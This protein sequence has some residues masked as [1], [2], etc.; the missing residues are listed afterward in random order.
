MILE[1]QPWKARLATDA[2]II[3]RWSSKPSISVR[4][5]TILEQKVFLAAYTIRRL[6]EANKLS[7]ALRDRAISCLQFP[8]I[9]HAKLDLNNNHKLDELYNFAAPSSIVVE[10]N[11]LVNVIIHSLAFAEVIN[12]DKTT[13]G[14]LVA[15]DRSR[16]FLWQVSV[17]EFTALMR[18]VSTDWPSKMIR[19]YDP[20]SDEWLYWLGN[21]EPPTEF[22]EQAERA[23]AATL[24][25]R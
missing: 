23:R 2:D 6:L 8:S 14:F 12:E 11:R 20:A 19:V 3:E 9:P 13:A 1:S 7:T 5:Y 22:V 10:N 4:R 21:G 24:A 18:T 15:S 25:G 16:K 17:L